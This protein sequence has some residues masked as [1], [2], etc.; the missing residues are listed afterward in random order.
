[1]PSDRPVEH[2]FACSRC[3]NQGIFPGKLRAKA[4][5]LLND[6]GWWSK[7]SLGRDRGKGRGDQYGI[8]DLC[9]ACVK[10]VESLIARQEAVKK[11]WDSQPR[12]A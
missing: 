6:A 8:E 4:R 12:I 7:L 1:M 10:W 9:P 5:Q 11:C 3:A 2:V